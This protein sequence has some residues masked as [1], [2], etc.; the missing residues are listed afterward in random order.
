M[1]AKLICVMK[2]IMQNLGLSPSALV[3]KKVT[4]SK[5]YENIHMD[6][7]IKLWQRRGPAITE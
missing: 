1:N 7:G 5:E 6:L 4:N 3:I 2:L